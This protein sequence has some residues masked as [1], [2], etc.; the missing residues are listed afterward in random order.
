MSWNNIINRKDFPW[1][2]NTYALQDVTPYALHSCIFDTGESAYKEFLDYVDN[3]LG[4]KHNESISEFGCGNGANLL[5]FRQKYNSPVS[6]IDISKPLIDFCNSFF[7]ANNFL[8]GST[9]PFESKSIDYFISNS[10]FQ[11]LDTFK[12][13]NKIIEEMCRVA[14]KAVLITDIKPLSTK[15][16]FK[17][18]QAQRQGLSLEELETKYKD[19]KH[20]FFDRN[21]FEHTFDMPTSF[22]DSE[23]GS[24]S[25]LICLE[26]DK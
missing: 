8:V 3:L 1:T 12:D 2:R 9:I 24:F 5:Y 11:Y 10:V 16:E 19:T 20:L 25:V 23:L 6:G 15:K 4:I 14:R 13:A 22:P 18:K 21:M 17:E 7:A 26:I